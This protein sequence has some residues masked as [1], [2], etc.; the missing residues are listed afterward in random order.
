MDQDIK[1]QSPRQITY[2]LYVLSARSEEAAGAGTVN[3]LSQASFNPPLIMVAAKADSGLHSV[4][5]KSGAFAVNFLSAD[6]KS[7]AEYFFDG[8][9][10]PWRCGERPGSTAANLQRYT[11]AIT[12]WPTLLQIRGRIFPSEW[13]CPSHYMKRKVFH[14]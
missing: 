12:R 3:W 1:K 10:S 9:T 13:G 2:G 4:I 5:E 6:Q 7:M 11:G 14:I 8:T